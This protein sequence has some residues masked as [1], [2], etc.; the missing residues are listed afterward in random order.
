VYYADKDDKNGSDFAV[1][2]SAWL[3][4]ACLSVRFD[5]L[6]NWVLKLEGHQMNGTAVMMNDNNPDDRKKEDWTLFG[7]KATF[8]F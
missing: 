5:L 6:D 1:D 3:K 7:A 4:D 8:S 2:H